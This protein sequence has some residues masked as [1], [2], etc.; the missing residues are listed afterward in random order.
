MV[1]FR[2][3]FDELVWLMNE[4]MLSAYPAWLTNSLDTTNVHNIIDSLVSK[5]ILFECEDRYAVSPVIEYLMSRMN[6][7]RIWLAVSNTY[8]IY[9]D[10]DIVVS[11]YN[12]SDT[13][14]T[15]TPY[16]SPRQCFLSV[17]SA[18]DGEIE[19]TFMVEESSADQKAFGEKVRM[20]WEGLYE[21][22][23]NCGGN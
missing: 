8:F 17:Q 10:S 15:V 6:R 7:A 11:L 20:I 12:A 5:E 23:K 1:G 16:E 14:I 13:R 9:I 22:R 19:Y 18:I 2:F 21:Q 3:S 4:S